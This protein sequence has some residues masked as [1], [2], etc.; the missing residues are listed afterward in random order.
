MRY[1]A[2]RLHDQPSEVGQPG[3]SNR[4][5]WADRA[6]QCHAVRFL[7]NMVHYLRRRPKTT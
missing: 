7:R 6:W 4:R 1:R 2:L 5:M 3:K